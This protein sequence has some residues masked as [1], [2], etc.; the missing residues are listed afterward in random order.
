MNTDKDG[1][2]RKDGKEKTRISRI[3]TN[4]LR[5][6]NGGQKDENR[7]SEEELQI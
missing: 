7:K 2:E 6:E 5:Q 1:W 4:F 3:L